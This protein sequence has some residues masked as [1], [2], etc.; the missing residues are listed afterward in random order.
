MGGERSL[1]RRGL[2]DY[3]IHSFHFIDAEADAQS[4]EGLDQVFDAEAQSRFRNFYDP[5]LPLSVGLPGLN[6]WID[7][8]HD[9]SYVPGPV[10]RI[11]VITARL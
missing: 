11:Q 3:L 2:G 1:T 5:P 6:W 4:E 9:A 10:L 8:L 7:S